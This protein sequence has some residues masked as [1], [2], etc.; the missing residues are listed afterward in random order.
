MIRK[1]YSAGAVKHSFWFV[2]FQRVAFLLDQGMAIA[3]IR[4][5]NKEE[6]LF[7]ASSAERTAMIM[8]TVA[9]RIEQL[10][11]TFLPLF[12]YGDSQTQKLFC[13]AAC[14][15]NDT[16]FFDFAYEVIREKIQLGTNEFDDS[17]LR[18][19]FKDKQAQSEKTAKWTDYTL[20]RLGSSYK[21]MLYEA[22]VTDHGKTVRKVIRPVIDREVEYWMKDNGLQP[23]LAALTGV[24][25]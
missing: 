22:G 3:D 17:D 2:E 13:L 23:V 21:T 15:C 19:F 25:E 5:K 14:L 10:P 24:N 9:A 6:N 8:N 12:V 20:K 4:K 18:L 1:E 7:A 11:R 16:L